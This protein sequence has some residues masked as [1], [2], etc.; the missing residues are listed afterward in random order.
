MTD[1]P[2]T[3]LLRKHPRW[4]KTIDL[5]NA[6]RMSAHLQVGNEAPCLLVLVLGCRVDP[7]ETIVTQNH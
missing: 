2:N 6:Q 5:L 4:H 1:S 3:A 7:D